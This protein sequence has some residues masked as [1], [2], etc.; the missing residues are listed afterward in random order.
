LEIKKLYTDAELFLLIAEGDEQAFNQFYLDLL[1]NVS[2]FLFRVV[3]SEEAVKDV[4]QESL[5]RFWLH[6]DKL[7]EID[8]VRGWFFRIVSNECYRYLSKMELRQRLAAQVDEHQSGIQYN[9]SH[10]TELDISFRETQRIISQ[11]VARLSP[12]QRTIYRMSR[13][14][15][16]TLPEIAGKLGLSRDYVKKTL[17]TALDIIRRKLIEAGRFLAAL[18]IL[19]AFQE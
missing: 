3:K 5:T 11:T 8:N 17:M 7:P 2:P 13:E 19:V 14:E 16:L 4:L 9:I 18:T 15:G 12:R 10:Q 1:P 6:R